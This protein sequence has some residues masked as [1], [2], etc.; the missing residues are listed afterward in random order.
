MHFF[1][2]LHFGPFC[3]FCCVVAFFFLHFLHFFL[4]GFFFPCWLHFLHFLAFS[5]FFLVKILA[6][7]ALERK[8]LTG[9]EDAGEKIWSFLNGLFLSQTP[10]FPCKL[11]FFFA[12][13]FAFFALFFAFFAFAFSVLPNCIL[14]H[15]WL[16]DDVDAAD[17][18]HAFS[19]S[20]YFILFYSV[21]GQKFEFFSILGSKT[22]FFFRFWGQ[23][24]IS[25]GKKSIF[26]SILWSKI[27][28][29]FSI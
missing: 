8:D 19:R 29:L 7:Y 25:G 17:P 14:A 4:K 5:G 6:F 24:P 12:F 21:F 11:H 13:F 9:A 23:K 18:F 15:P 10:F 20:F 26:F 22:D 16:S 1:F 3:I 28:F 27:D 2:F